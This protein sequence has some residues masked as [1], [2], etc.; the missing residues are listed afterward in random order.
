MWLRLHYWRLISSFCLKHTSIFAKC[1]VFAVCSH[2]LRR[3][4]WVESSLFV[5]RTLAST[6]K[7]LRPLLT[8]WNVWPFFFLFCFFF[9]PKHFWTPDELLHLAWQRK[10]PLIFLPVIRPFV[11]IRWY[12]PFYYKICFYSFDKGRTVAEFILINERLFG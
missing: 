7:R 5:S 2:S 6:N 12:F 3:T 11:M 1:P 4:H 9:V 8:F 10:T